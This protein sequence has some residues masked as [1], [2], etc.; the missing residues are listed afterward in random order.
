MDEKHYPQSYSNDLQAVQGVKN[1]SIQSCIMSRLPFPMGQEFLLYLILMQPLTN[2]K[3]NSSIAPNFFLS[4]F[5]NNTS[6]IDDSYFSVLHSK[7][8]KKPIRIDNEIIQRKDKSCL[9]KIWLQGFYLAKV[10]NKVAHIKNNNEALFYNLGF[11]F[12]TKSIS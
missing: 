10:N 9:D 7:F 12:Q 5:I 2:S 1:K 3:K 6:F 4:N 11:N 8:R